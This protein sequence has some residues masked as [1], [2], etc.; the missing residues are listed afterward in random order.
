MNIVTSDIVC[1]VHLGAINVVELMVPALACDIDMLLKSHGG[2]SCDTNVT[3]LL[4]I[5]W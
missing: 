1:E 2:F 4:I 3:S 5:Q